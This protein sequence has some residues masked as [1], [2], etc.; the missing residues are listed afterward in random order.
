VTVYGYTVT[1]YGFLALRFTG[2]RVFSRLPRI[3]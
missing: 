1:I 2:F 3:S